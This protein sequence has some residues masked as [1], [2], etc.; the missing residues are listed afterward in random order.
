VRRPPPPPPPPRPIAEILE[1]VVK[2]KP[3]AEVPDEPL[4][5][6][7]VEAEREELLDK[8]M[9]EIIDDPEAAYRTVAVLY[10]DFLVRCRIHR[11]PGEPLALPAFRRRLAVAQASGGDELINDEKWQTALRLSESLTDDVQ[12]VFLIVAQAA[13][14]AA[15][16]P[17]DATL[18]RAYGSHSTSRARR[19]LTYFE[20]RGLLV[21]R[22]DFK[23]M[24]VVAF[25]DMGCETAAGDPNG[26]DES[27]DS[28]EAAE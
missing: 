17:S 2:S 26:P 12:G 11:V 27:A 21:V 10:Q 25:P 14:K 1:Q 5:P 3:E 20:E 7:L 19:L 24:R 9:T 18:A 13:V 23:G 22:N 6:G 15:P 8:V 28:A 4:F 16:C